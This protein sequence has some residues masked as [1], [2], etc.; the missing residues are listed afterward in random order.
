[1][2]LLTIDEYSSLA[3]AGA[4]ADFQTSSASTGSLGRLSDLSRILSPTPAVPTASVALGRSSDRAIN[5]F[6][7]NPDSG[8]LL[9][10]GARVNPSG[11]SGVSLFLND[12]LVI[13]GG[14]SGT[15]TDE[16]AT[17]TAAL[18]RYTS[19]VGVRAAVIIYTA[20][21]TQIRTLTASY[22]NQAGTP[23]RTS[24]IVVGG[25]GNREIGRV[26]PFRLEGADTGVRS[27]EH[28]TLDGTTGT[29]GNFGILLYRPL[30]MMCLNNVEGATVIDAVST[31]GF[32]GSLAEVQSDACLSL[33]TVWAETQLLTGAI[34]LGEA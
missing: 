25:T 33:M 15:S 13:S 20:V 30:A 9:V 24:A 11:L 21:G 31:G 27:V 6:V 32:I 1:V 22:T 5:S 23:G 18:T 17:T 8:K 26:L 19:G 16:Q 12:Y 34:L 28:V 2:P 10:L 4:A 29:L 3:A 7:A 14:L